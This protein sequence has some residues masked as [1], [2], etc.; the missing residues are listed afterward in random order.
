MPDFVTTQA[1]TS[2]AMAGLSKRV[3]V[4]F[5]YSAPMKYTVA[6]LRSEEAEGRAW[7]STNPPLNQSQCDDSDRTIL[8]C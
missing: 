1:D 7:A 4:S 8:S 5:A 3:S 6:C 2:C